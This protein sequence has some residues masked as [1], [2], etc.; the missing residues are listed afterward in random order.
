[1]ADDGDAKTAYQNVNL[2]IGLGGWLKVSRGAG[3]VPQKIRLRSLQLTEASSKLDLGVN[4]L[5]VADPDWRKDRDWS[6]SATVNVEAYNHV[7]GEIL[8][9]SRGLMLIVR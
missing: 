1:M 3:N 9:L 7:Y 2:I 4:F 6:P 5:E 8:W